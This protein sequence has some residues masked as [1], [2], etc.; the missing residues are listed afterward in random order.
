[1]SGK[2]RLRRELAQAAPQ[3]GALAR[4]RA[5]REA[6]RQK[7]R[8]QRREA[9]AKRREA[10]RRKVQARRRKAQRRK[11]KARARV[12]AALGRVVPTLFQQASADASRT[13]AQRILAVYERARGLRTTP[14]RAF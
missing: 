10:E 1:M 3:M 5:E 2:A 11:A 8:D 12:M 14:P 13:A 9:E 6:A 4:L 7:A